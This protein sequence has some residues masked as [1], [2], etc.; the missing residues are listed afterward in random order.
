MAKISLDKEKIESIQIEID[1]L[2]NSL[3][4]EFS[5]ELDDELSAIK[6]NVLGDELHET[7]NK[8]SSNLKSI[9]TDI[10]TKFNKLSEFLERQLK[11]Y[12]ITEEELDD[13]LLNL[14]NKMREVCGEEP[15]EEGTMA[16]IKTFGASSLSK[17]LDLGEG[18]FDAHVYGTSKIAQLFGVDDKWAEDIISYEVIDYDKWINNV[19]PNIKH[20]TAESVGNIVGTIGG[21]TAISN[22]P[23]VGV[24]LATFAGAGTKTEDSINT[25]KSSGGEVNDLRTLGASLVG[26]AEGYSSA[27]IGKMFKEPMKGVATAARNQGGNAAANVVK[28]AAG[29][30]WKGAATVIKNTPKTVIKDSRTWI[31]AGANDT[32]QALSKIGGYEE[33]S[34]VGSILTTAAPNMG[35]SGLNV[36]T[37]LLK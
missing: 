30:G 2:T 11:T 25:Q 27:S 13:N 8:I 19:S 22:I 17:F 16:Y 6:Q 18:V 33:K 4:N 9:T 5:P 23:K 28:A 1:F 35:V 34:N 36:I 20:G 14:L 7:I 29:S 10:G 21:Y 32:Q 31:T 12:S 15:F 3:Q 37:N 26:S 24:P